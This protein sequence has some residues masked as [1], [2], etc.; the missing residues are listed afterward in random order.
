MINRRVVLALVLAGIVGVAS[1]HFAL[2]QDKKDK[3]KPAAADQDKKDKDKAPSTAV[4]EL[5]KDSA[6]E[7]RFRLKDSEGNLLATSGKG[8]ATKADCQKVIDTIKS[9]VAK[10]KVEEVK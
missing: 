4:F 7:F 10:A 5:Y 1:P 2:A 8:Y 6:D 3:D 9:A